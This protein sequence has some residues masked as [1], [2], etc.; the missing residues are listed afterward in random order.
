MYMFMQNIIKVSAAVHELPCPEA[1]W[2]YLAKG[3]KSENPAVTLTFD[4]TLKF[5]RVRAVVEEHVYAKFHRAKC[6]G[7]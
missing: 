2:R 6:S 7:S 5:N 3:E 1:F 4:M